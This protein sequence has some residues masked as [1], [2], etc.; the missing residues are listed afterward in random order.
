VLQGASA[1]VTSRTRRTAFSLSV[2][3]TTTTTTVTTALAAATGISSGPLPC[4]CTG[5][6]SATPHTILTNTDLTAQVDT[7]D[8]WIATRTGIRSRHVLQHGGETLQQLSTRAALRALEMAGVAAND[9]DLVICATSSSDDLFGDAPA[10]AAAIGFLFGVV[11]AGQFLANSS[12]RKNNNKKQ[13]KALVIGADALSKWVDWDDRNV[14]ILFGDAAGA[15]VLEAT[16]LND[17]D[18]PEQAGVLGY[19]AHSNGLGACDLHCLYVNCCVCTCAFVR[20]C[21]HVPMC[22]CFSVCHYFHSFHRPTTYAT[23]H[24][25]KDD[26]RHI[27]TP[28]AD[29]IILSRGRYGVTTMNGSEVYKFATREVPMVLTEVLEASG[30]T[31]DNLDWLLLHQANIRIMQTVAK[32]LNVPMEKVLTNLAEYGNTSAASIPLA[33]DEAVRSGQVKKGDV[34]ACAGFGAGLSW[35]A[36]V[37]KWG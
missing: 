5:I 30:L 31:V 17:D 4:R 25:S 11:T 27:N 18:E 22:W 16:A 26:P 6:G 12:S 8:E 24:R 36:A 19:A 13:L 2:P 35:G 9:I 15:M 14:C 21:V 34:I 10:I 20:S 29:E 3:S 23:T 37:L 28:G 1:F 33:L 32:R 7:T